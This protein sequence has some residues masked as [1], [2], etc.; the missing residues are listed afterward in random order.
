MKLSK[1]ELSRYS[2]Q[3]PII[4]IDGQL[5]LKNSNILVVGSGGLGSPVLL[6]LAAAGIGSIT[7]IDG[8]NIDYTNLQRQIVFN[9]NEVGKNKAQQA[10]LNLK[11]LNSACSYSYIPE[12]LTKKNARQ[13]I[14]SRDI[15]VD[16]SD[17]FET[18][19][20]INTI[21]REFSIPLVSASI[22]KFQAQISV[23]NYKGGPCYECLYPSQPPNAFMPN[24]SEN[25]VIGSLPGVAG[26]IQATEVFKI[27]LGLEGILS[28]KLLTIDLLSHKY[29]TFTI[30]KASSCKKKQC[31]HNLLNNLETKVEENIF[32][33]TPAELEL[34]L[35]QSP[36]DYV[37]LDVREEYER[38]CFSLGGLSIPLQEL[39]NRLNEIPRNK[40][41]IVYCQ[42][43]KR[44]IVALNKLRKEFKD[45]TYLA[46]GIDA[47]QKST[48][49]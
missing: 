42:T 3:F 23:F 9:E 44:S 22:L 43:S 7:A 32:S 17:N 18:R 11:E 12:N 46:G 24:C 40:K 25:G 8:D 14:K 16:C 15:I 33:I 45:I 38:K 2:R 36:N 31:S 48:I 29:Q 6:Y 20:L 30:S 13:L 1:D 28:G 4:G 19:Y 41:I 10:I 26:S 35:R 34:E 21:S 37:L 47:Y 39:P 5:K 49:E 27:L